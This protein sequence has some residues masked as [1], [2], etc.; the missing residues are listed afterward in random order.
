[1]RHGG[2][3]IRTVSVGTRPDQ[4]KFPR[5]AGYVKTLEA[6]RISFSE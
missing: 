6:E 1:M 2:H 3:L 4:N 5:I